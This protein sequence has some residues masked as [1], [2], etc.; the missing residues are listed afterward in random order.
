MKSLCFV[1]GICAFLITGLSSQAVLQLDQSFD[2]GTAG[3]GSYEAVSIGPLPYVAPFLQ[4]Q[5]FTVGSAGQ[6]DR[7]DIL[8]RSLASGTS[9]LQ[10]QLRKTQN[11][12]PLSDSDPANVLASGTLNL[13]HAST[14]EWAS[15]D[16]S[17]FNLAVNKGEQLAI[18]LSSDTTIDWGT[19]LGTYAGGA[20]YRSHPG[21][22]WY[23]DNLM[24]GDPADAGF[25]T[26]VDVSTVP[27]PSTCIAGALLLL[28]F[29]ASIFRKFRKAS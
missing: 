4:A 23:L 24:S 29:G 14:I 27:E 26:W 20:L 21:G 16:S 28:P 17:S 6:L 12:L 3:S 8:V 10:W 5:M 19:A 22:A 15:I 11:G 1:T 13:T 7:F 2:P 9:L 18:V 25:R